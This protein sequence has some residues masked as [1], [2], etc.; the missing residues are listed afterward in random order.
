MFTVYF[1]SGLAVGALIA[2]LAVR[3]SYA[4]RWA[5]EQTL[6]TVAEQLAEERQQL[7]DKLNGELELIRK[8]EADAR[9]AAARLEAELEAV[10]RQLAERTEFLA[11]AEET[12]AKTFSDL[13]GQVLKGAQT[14][15]L[16]MA[17][18][19]FKNQRETSQVEMDKRKEAVE[20]LVKP[21]AETLDKL[22]INLNAI[23]NT[24]E[25]AYQ[26]LREQV[27]AIIQSQTG[28][29]K[30][31]ARLVQALRTPTGRGQWGELQ[32]KKV[33]EM[34]G[35][36]EHCDF[37]T[38][39]THNDEDGNRLRPDVIVRLPGGRSIVID[40]KSPMDAYL[41]AL[42][43]EEEAERR[44]HLQHHARQVRTHLNQLGTKDY[45]SRV[46]GS[47]EFV[48]LFL[49]SE[50]FFQAALEADASLIQCGVDKN[51]ILAT[52]TTLIALL[53][54]VAYGWRQEVL[55]ENA[56]KISE[57]GTELYDRC[58]V[59]SSHFTDLGKSL[60][61]SVDTYN[62][63][64]ASFETRVISGARILKNLGVMGKKELSDPSEINT[65]TRAPRVL[66]SS[67]NEGE[68]PSGTERPALE[69]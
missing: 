14:Q 24:R 39:E 22:Q 29:Q 9:A 26:A 30:E 59:L 54:A 37:V 49:P 55:A 8:A 1:L 3:S 48:V 60:Q 10:G 53:R 62:K 7:L 4:A 23:E 36:V 33:V 44:E 42:E 15:F 41:R 35:M 34:A 5:S 46:A 51:V 64:I 56:R 11:R 58:S 43:C 20:A 50:A 47:P 16:E 32:L 2:Y 61:K 57:A 66:A 63:T 52:P 17:Q 27:G 25:G 18:E 13:S 40:S 65:T 38:Q 45:W 6:R 67:A 68:A 31:T 19:G 69:D 12:L 21:V 28:L